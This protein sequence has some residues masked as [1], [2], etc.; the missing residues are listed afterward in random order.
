MAPDGAND[1]VAPSSSR[2]A[3]VRSTLSAV[4]SPLP[5]ADAGRAQADCGSRTGR[6]LAERGPSAG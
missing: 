5:G 6:A 3:A 4:L 1:S 2:R